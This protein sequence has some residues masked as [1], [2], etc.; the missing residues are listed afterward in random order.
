MK[1]R[2]TWHKFNSLKLRDEFQ[3]WLDKA[4]QEIS[5]LIKQYAKENAPVKTWRLRN[6]I[7]VMKTWLN[8]Q[9]WS[10]L[11]YAW[12][13]EQDAASLRILWIPPNRDPNTEHYL[14]RAYTEHKDEFEDIFYRYV[15]RAVSNWFTTEKYW[16]FLGDSLSYN[17]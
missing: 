4:T 14:E 9:V 15:S 7:R 12:V 2:I 6:S 17:L 13:R 5:S 3:K 16:E 1:F 8:A 10:T 11:D